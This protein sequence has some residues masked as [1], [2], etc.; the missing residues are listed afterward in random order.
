[1]E[2]V[3]AKSRGR[4]WNYHAVLVALGGAMAL[5]SVF[6][7]ALCYLGTV[8]MCIAMFIDAIVLLRLMIAR[9][10]NECG[11]GWVFYA[12]LPYLAMPIFLIMQHA[13]S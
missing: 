4:K 10:L 13:W 2:E 6:G 11:K 9:M 7:P 3:E 5:Q 8:N 12:V 1:M